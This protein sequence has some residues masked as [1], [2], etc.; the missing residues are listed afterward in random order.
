MPSRSGMADWEITQALAKAM[1]LAWN[2][3]HP[4]EIM[5]EISRTSP[6]STGV[7]YDTLDKYGSVQWPCNVK[8]PSG[9]PVMHID[10]FA[11]GRG[12]FMI[13]EYVP[14][15]ERSGPRFPLLLTTGRILS[16]YNIRM[17]PSSA[18]CARAPGCGCRVGRAKPA[19]VHV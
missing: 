13:T 18:A 8:A 7:S 17:M 14:T 6:S 4:S 2:Y 5:D 15:E 16:Q 19:C 10:S 3:A 1:G 11:R 9:T 12:R